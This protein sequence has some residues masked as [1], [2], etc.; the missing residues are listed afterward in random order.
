MH[1]LPNDTIM[2]KNL[3]IGN[4]ANITREPFVISCKRK[5]HDCDTGMLSKTIMKNVLMIEQANEA[6]ITREPFVIP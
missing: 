4:E 6:N 3:M 2:K 1:V 5:S